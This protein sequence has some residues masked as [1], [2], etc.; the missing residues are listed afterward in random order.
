MKNLRLLVT[1]YCPKNCEMCCNK[2]Q[3]LA[4]LPV[5]DN[6]DNYNEI[7]IT[8]GEPLTEEAFDKTVSLVK[9]LQDWYDSKRVIIYTADA[10]GLYRFLTKNKVDGVTFSIHSNED[11]D[12]FYQLNSL[13]NS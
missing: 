7:I 2:D 5:V 10:F 6:F 13:I 12:K 4:S 3:D 9:Y 1:T 8:G 11:L